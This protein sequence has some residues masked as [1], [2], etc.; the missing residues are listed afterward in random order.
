L[1]QRLEKN[2][3]EPVEVIEGLIQYTTNGDK[4]A[5]WAFV[6]ATIDTVRNSRVEDD[7]SVVSPP[8]HVM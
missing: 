6:L 7:A 2:K 5:M 3:K 8:C 4:D 1:H